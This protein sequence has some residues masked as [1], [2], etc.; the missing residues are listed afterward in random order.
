[1]H[2][3]VLHAAETFGIMVCCILMKRMV[4]GDTSR[5]LSSR[6]SFRTIRGVASPGGL[7]S[8]PIITSRF[9]TPVLN[10]RGVEVVLGQGVG[11][12]SGH[13]APHAPL[14]SVLKAPEYQWF[15]REGG[16]N[17]RPAQIRKEPLPCG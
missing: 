14:V 10:C 17:S 16:I 2:L 11:G 9:L 12:L 8:V 4:F 7:G 1:M 3:S 6:V 15:C 13:T 5:L